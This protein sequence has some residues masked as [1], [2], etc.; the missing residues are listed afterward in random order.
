MGP[1]DNGRGASCRCCDLVGRVDEAPAALA[2]TPGTPLGLGVSSLELAAPPGPQAPLPRP[3]LDKHFEPALDENGAL[4]LAV[5]LPLSSQVD[6]EPPIRHFGMLSFVGGPRKQQQGGHSIGIPEILHG[7]VLNGCSKD[8]ARPTGAINLMEKLGVP[9]PLAVKQ[10]K[11]GGGKCEVFKAPFNKL[12]LKEDAEFCYAVSDKIKANVWFQLMLY[13]DIRKGKQ[14]HIDYPDI[15]PDVPRYVTGPIDVAIPSCPEEG[16]A[17]PSCLPDKF[18][19]QMSPDALTFVPQAP[20]PA[21]GGLE[22]QDPILS[23]KDE[24]L[25]SVKKALDGAELVSFKKGLPPVKLSW[26]SMD[27]EGSQ[28]GLVIAMLLRKA[29]DEGTLVSQAAKLFAMGT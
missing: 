23:I 6:L 10:G 9:L 21:H 17:I 2:E 18:P 12:K 16:V 19:K 28:Q 13:A 5:R 24:M 8:D 15:P 4:A 29:A 7:L 1:G 27:I 11:E 14:S 3:I 22:K 20:V 25:T 26:D